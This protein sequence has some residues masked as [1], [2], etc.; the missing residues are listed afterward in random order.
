[1]N[2]TVILYN[3]LDKRT[4][5]VHSVAIVSKKNAKWF[6]PVADNEEEK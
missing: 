5:K 1:M 4:N 2:Q 6:I 3:V